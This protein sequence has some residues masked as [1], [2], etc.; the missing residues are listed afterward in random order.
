MSNCEVEGRKHLT[1]LS[2]VT[3]ITE[4]S[5]NRAYGARLGVKKRERWLRVERNRYVT[6]LYNATCYISTFTKPA[7]LTW[8]P[9]D[10]LRGASLCEWR[11][12]HAA[13]SDCT[14]HLS[15]FLI[16]IENAMLKIRATTFAHFNRDTTYIFFVNRLKQN[17]S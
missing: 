11:D 7:L 3:I 12:M 17:N 6:V 16:K 5:V 2:F 14:Q 8:K 9:N 1:H 13:K 15:I 4:R 10:A